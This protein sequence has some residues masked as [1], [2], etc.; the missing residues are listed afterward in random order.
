MAKGK[1]GT[2]K[3]PKEIAGIK[4]PKELRKSGE[5]LVDALSHPLIADVAAAA[6]LGA[7]AALRDSDSVRKVSGSGKRS[8]GA[9]KLA[10]DAT[11]YGVVLLAEKA[12]EGAR[13]LTA[14]SAAGKAKPAPVRKKKKK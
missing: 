7:A 5:K 14:A 3:L 10:E 4:L 6:L 9:R 1:T 2:T 12:L 11:A 8:E 13:L